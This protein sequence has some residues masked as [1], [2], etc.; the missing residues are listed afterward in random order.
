M[1][2]YVKVISFLKKH[3]AVNYHSSEKNFTAETHVQAEPVGLWSLP[4]LKRSSRV[5]LGRG[6]CGLSAGAVEGAGPGSLLSA[7]RDGSAPET[8]FTGMFWVN[9]LL[10]Q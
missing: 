4:D 9:I 8:R 2:N 10:S 7:W 6:F 5:L 3:D 1:L